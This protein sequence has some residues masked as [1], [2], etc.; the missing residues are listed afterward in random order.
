M[1]RARKVAA[2]VLGDQQLDLL[3]PGSVLL[4]RAVLV[5]QQLD[6]SWSELLGTRAPPQGG[7]PV[8]MDCGASLWLGWNKERME[9]TWVLDI[10]QVS[11]NE[12][13]N[14][15]RSKE[16]LMRQRQQFLV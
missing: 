6:L 10:G 3:V 13:E 16:N 1:N 5:A 8:R 9:A 14:H 4:L 15:R 12:L 7:A 11:T 2:Y